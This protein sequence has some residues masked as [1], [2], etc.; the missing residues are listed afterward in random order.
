MNIIELL[1]KNAKERP[2]K[3]ALIH[4]GK[5]MTYQELEDSSQALTRFFTINEVCEGKKALLFIPLSIE[6]YVIFLALVRSGVSVVLIDPSAGKDKVAQCVKAAKPDAFIA[7]PKAHLLRFI[8]AVAAIPKKFSTPGTFG[9]IPGSKV[10]RYLESDGSNARINGSNGGISGGKN[11]QDFEAPSDYPALITFTSGS[12]GIPKG[13]SRSHG[14]LINQ[15]KAISHAL[16]AMENDVELNTLP[17][18][19]LS[20]L[21]NGITTVIPDVDV[22]NNATVDAK[23]IVRQMQTNGVNRILAAPAFCKNIAD[24]LESQKQS[25]PNMQRLYTGGGPVFPH[26]LKQLSVVFPNAEVIALYGST[27]AEPIA[28]IGMHEID[29]KVLEKMQKG[30]G[31][32]TGKPISDIKLAIIP[33]KDGYPIGPFTSEEFRKL[34]LF[35]EHG[36]IEAHGK[37]AVQG[38]IVVTGEHV[39][40]SY[41]SGDEGTTKFKVED[42]IWHRTGD[43]GYLDIDGN[44]WLLGRCSAKIVKESKTIYPFGIEASAMSFFGVEKAAL[45][46]VDGVIILAIET[47]IKP[48]LVLF[49]KIKIT[50]NEVLCGEIKKTLSDV[51]SVV[52]LKK[53]PVDKRHNSK[54]LYAELKKIIAAQ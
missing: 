38:E 15:H 4:K 39:Q 35:A 32:L 10:I 29:D 42:V 44:L 30:S 23:Q 22:K 6:F 36:E 16:P 31:L 33:D 8:S 9:W 54:V 27:E 17:V 51:D 47:K 13:I 45:V 41:I 2:N 48:C 20:N 12:T 18:F 19:I 26:L 28:H 49:G 11:F 46:E 21:A 1:K 5:K 53:I 34:S 3:V 24:Y 37:N 7:T 40:K 25:L 50:F 43:A 14:F 52:V